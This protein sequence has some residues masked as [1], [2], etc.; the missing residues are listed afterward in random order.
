[1]CFARIWGL[2]WCFGAIPLESC[3]Q[4]GKIVPPPDIISNPQIFRFQAKSAEHLGEPVLGDLLPA[5]DFAPWP[6]RHLTSSS[7]S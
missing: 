7:S 5:V 6:L 3:P 1:M 2:R 4:V